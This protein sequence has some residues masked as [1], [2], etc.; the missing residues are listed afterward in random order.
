MVQLTLLAALFLLNFLPNKGQKCTT[1]IDN[2]DYLSEDFIRSSKDRIPPLIVSPFDEEIYAKIGY[3]LSSVTGYHTGSVIVEDH[4]KVCGLR[5]IGIQGYLNY[6]DDSNV[7]SRG[8]GIPLISLQNKASRVKC[9]KG[10]IREFN[11]IV[12]IVRDPLMSIF[13]KL[14]RHILNNESIMKLAIDGA[15][16]YSHDL[17]RFIIPILMNLPDKDFLILK[18]EDLFESPNS[19]HSIQK[20]LNFLDLDISVSSSHIDTSFNRTIA[21]CPRSIHDVYMNDLWMNV[22]KNCSYIHYIKFFNIYFNYSIDFSHCNEVEMSDQTRNVAVRDL[23]KCKDHFGQVLSY[24]Y[25]TSK[26]SI[27]LLISF[28]GSGNTW[29]HLQFTVYL[30]VYLFIHSL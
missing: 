16:E 2:I 24:N 5:T 8:D 6:F 12:L 9:R 22:R 28:P 27:P 23:I 26:E 20:L 21:A 18:F 1:N 29:Y 7:N 13:S 14:N 25:S 30:L 15:K 19:Y 17:Q 10:V 3:L 4:E 11:R